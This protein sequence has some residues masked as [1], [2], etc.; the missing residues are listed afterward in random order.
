M[1]IEISEGVERKHCVYKHTC[2]NGK[3]YIG[4]TKKRPRD[5]WANGL[6]YAEQFFG[7]AI[8]KY[9]WEN[10]KHEIIAD[11]LTEEEAKQKEIEQI[12]LHDSHNPEHGYNCTD[13]GDGASGHTVSE[14]ERK[15]MKERSAK[16]W[17]NEEI[18]EKLLKHLAEISKA[19]VGRKR[20]RELVER[21]IERLSMSVDQYDKSGLFIQ[22]HKS[23]MDAARYLG[24]DCNSAIVACCKGKKKS[25]CG[26][27]WKYHGEE[28]TEEELAWR[29][30]KDYHKR[31]IVM[32][33]D[34]WN[35]IK[36]F[37]GFHDAGRELGLS[38]KAIHSAC[39]TGRHCGGYRWQYAIEE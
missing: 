17:E 30:S 34:A 32:C 1:D 3:V 13:G 10:I 24:K 12:A 14:E 19:N 26:Y 5:R 2:P 21:Q 15:R 7:K 28:I 39:K 25:Y 9:G 20:S 31:E 37:D 6:G 29:N 16:M 22:T 11:G 4:I 38:Y 36:R 35:E 8:R 27:I 23:L 33:D 18:R